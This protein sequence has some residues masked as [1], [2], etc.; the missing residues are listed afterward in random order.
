[1]KIEKYVVILSS[2]NG[3]KTHLKMN[4][5]KGE[6]RI[7]IFLAESA[8]FDGGKLYVFADEIAKQ[9]LYKDKKEYKVLVCA[10]DRIDLLLNY[11]GKIYIGSTVKTPKIIELKRRV[12]AY[13]KDAENSVKINGKIVAC[14]EVE[15]CQ[16][17]QENQ[18]ENLTDFS[19]K[20]Q[21]GNTC[22]IGENVAEKYP[23]KNDEFDQEKIDSEHTKECHQN[24]EEKRH[25]NDCVLQEQECAKDDGEVGVG[26]AVSAVNMQSGPCGKQD[27]SK[28]FSFDTVRFDGS[29]FYLSVKPQIDEIFVCYPEEEALNA[30]V[31]NSKW[32][33]INTPDGYYVVGLILD[34]DVVSYICYGVPS[35]DRNLPPKEIADFAVWLPNGKNQCEGY[36]IIYQDA[37]T[38]K[39]LK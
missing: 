7:E 10:N 39:C 17:K 19:S 26:N 6:N 36:W 8:K 28:V 13:E 31:P 21:Q 15:N 23:C 27:E 16:N 37:L 29:N 38:G 33:H 11:G 24:S 35:V 3:D 20:I 25:K 22:Q 34:G 32:A 12:Y 30:V 14:Q 1:M 5:F 9:A 4:V 18:G 2:E